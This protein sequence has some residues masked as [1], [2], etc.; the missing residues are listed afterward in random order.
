M[1]IRFNKPFLTGKEEAYVLKALHSGHLAGDGAFT[2][3]CHALFS[4]RFGFAHNYLTTSGTHAIEMAA[5]LAG[6]QAGDEVIMPSYTFVSTANA[7]V[8]R[9]ATIRF[10]DSLPDQPNMDTSHAVSLIN[11]RTKAIVPVHYAGVANDMDVLLNATRGKGIQIIE[12]AAHSIAAQYKGRWLGSLGHFG[13][14]SFHET[15]NIVAGEGGL[16]VVNRAEEAHRA[17]IIREKGT[18]RSAFFRGE[19][20]KYGWV[21]MGSSYLPSELIAAFLLAQLEEVDRIQSM[22][23]SVWNRY[24]EGLKGIEEYGVQLPVI[25]DYATNNAHMFYLVCESI[26]Q[27]THLISYLKERGVKAVFHYLPLHLSEFWLKEH[28]AGSLPHVERYAD[29]LV[30]LPLFPDLASDDQERI[31]QYIWE[32]LR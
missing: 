14:F 21:D 7:F 11:S 16:F 29:Y 30:R 32:A 19:I 10:A 17:E 25:P 12:D 20:D 27:R 24:N 22:R 13:C 4:E 3:A 31:I 5:L 23:M 15:K 8:L 9:G 18:N 28:P 26:E 2:K 1:E 6:I